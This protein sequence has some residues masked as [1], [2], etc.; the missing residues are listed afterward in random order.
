MRIV[1]VLSFAT[2]FT[3]VLVNIDSPT[4]ECTPISFGQ[5]EKSSPSKKSDQNLSENSKMEE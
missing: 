1:R 5:P 2:T 3:A 4:F